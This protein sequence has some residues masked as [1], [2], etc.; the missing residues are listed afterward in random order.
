MLKLPM[1]TADCHSVRRLLL[2]LAAL[3][4]L[5]VP[6]SAGAGLGVGVTDDLGRDSADGGLSFVS[7]LGDLGFTENRVSVVWDPDAPTTI[8]SRPAL[9][10]Y[11]ANASA[12]GVRVV[13]A[14]YPGR[15]TAVADSPA[16]VGQF[17]AFLGD[18]ARTYPQVTDFVVGNEPNQPFFWRPQFAS[19]G[20]PVGCGTYEPLLAASYDALKAV[21][22]AI[23]VIGLG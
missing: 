2:V 10:R 13:L 8:P 19:T 12:A 11:V 1:A 16:V 6:G 22:P 9:D 17:A 21:N 14:V 3:A 23:T 7:T 20:A 5:A 4:V 18:V 15:P